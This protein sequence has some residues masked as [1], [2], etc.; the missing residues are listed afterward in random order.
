MDA[1]YTLTPGM[2]LHYLYGAFDGYAETGT[3]APLTVGQQTTC[4]LRRPALPS[5]SDAANR[6]DQRSTPTAMLRPVNSAMVLM[7]AK[8]FAKAGSFDTAS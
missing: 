4:R 5:R 1:T 6:G 2:R 7:C 8:S 3:T